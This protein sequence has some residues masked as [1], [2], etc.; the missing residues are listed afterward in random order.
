MMRCHSCEVEREEGREEDTLH[1]KENERRGESKRVVKELEGGQVS[2]IMRRLTA[3][4]TKKEEEKV[5]K[6]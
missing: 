6:R 1:S 4:A 5:S 2:G 3:K